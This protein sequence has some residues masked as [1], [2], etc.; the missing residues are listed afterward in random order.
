LKNPIEQIKA[1]KSQKESLRFYKTIISKDDLCFDIGANIGKKSKLFLKCGAR[2]VA[3]EPQTSCHKMLDKITNLNF[4][5][6]KT[7]IGLKAE[8]RKLHLSDFTEIA[9]LSDKFI[10]SYSSQRC[11]WTHSETVAVNTLN[12]SIEKHGLPNYCKIDVEGLE[13]E[14]LSNL[15]YNI[16]VIEFEFTKEFIEETLKCIQYLS[17]M[18]YQFNYSKNNNLKLGFSSWQPQKEFLPI[19]KQLAAHKIHANIFCKQLA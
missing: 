19:I 13:W 5:C 7:A 14:V 15:Q 16:P 1:Y 3:F 2:V 17:K 11:K 6:V 8:E 10:A 9:T 4:T 18:G 12:Y